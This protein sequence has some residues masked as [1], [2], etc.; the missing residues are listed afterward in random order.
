MLK[1]YISFQF[2]K[3]EC[4]SSPNNSAPKNETWFKKFEKNDTKDFEL[5]RTELNLVKAF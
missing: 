2:V 1:P 5:I 4:H 3:I